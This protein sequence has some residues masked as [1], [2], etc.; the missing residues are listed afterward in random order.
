MYAGVTSIQSDPDR[1]DELL[2]IYRDTVVPLVGQ[3]PGQ[4]GL[5][6]LVDWSMGRSI[7]IGLWDT[8]EDARAYETSGGFR[9]AVAGFGDMFQSPP[10]REVYEVAVKQG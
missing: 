3:Q 8:E 6:L 7:S 5:L 10:V 2:A 1:V 9:E 4:Q